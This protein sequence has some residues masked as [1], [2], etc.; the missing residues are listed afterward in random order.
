[1]GPLRGSEG[2]YHLR[3]HEH[4]PSHKPVVLLCHEHGPSHKPV[5]LLCS[6]DRADEE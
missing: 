3:R 6:L 5:V 4:G 2:V 1:M